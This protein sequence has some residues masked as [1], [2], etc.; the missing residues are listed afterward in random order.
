VLG[1]EPDLELVTTQ[2]V[3]HQEIVGAP[4]AVLL[5]LVDPG[6]DPFD[7]GFVG[8]EK[9]GSGE[10]LCALVPLTRALDFRGFVRLGMALSAP[11]WIRAGRDVRAAAGTSSP[12]Q[13]SPARYYPCH[14]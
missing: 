3:T 11:S 9:S 13:F 7:D 12:R 2:H 5:G 1:H 8:V 4:V 6:P 14:G 10:R